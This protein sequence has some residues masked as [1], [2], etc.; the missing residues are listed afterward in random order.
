[1]AQ[2]LDR[3]CPKCKDCLGVV[4]H[5]LPEPVT[6]L[7]IDARCL[8]YGFILAWKVVLAQRPG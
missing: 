1:M 8:R 6:E 2:Y 3:T 7:P 5:E 4:V